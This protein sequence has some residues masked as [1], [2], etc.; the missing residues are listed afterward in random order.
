MLKNISDIEF[1]SKDQLGEGAYSQFFKVK[2]KKT[3][4]IFALKYVRNLIRLIFSKLE[5][6]I[7][8]I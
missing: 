4:K 3:Q 2:H 8:R 5:R 7:A 6:R 1:L